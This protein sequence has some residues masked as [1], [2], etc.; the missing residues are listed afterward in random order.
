MKVNHKQMYLMLKTQAKALK[1]QL[2]PEAVG[3][4]VNEIPENFNQVG[5][6]LTIEKVETL[7][8]KMKA[9]REVRGKRLTPQFYRSIYNRAL[10]ANGEI[11][12]LYETLTA[13]AETGVD[14]EAE[15]VKLNAEIFALNNQLAEKLA[16]EEAE[17]TAAEAEQAKA[18]EAAQT[19]GDSADKGKGNKTA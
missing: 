17:R 9:L 5:W 2:N 11:D 1:A 6:D 3:E 7:L 13:E 4:Q 16:K 19:N 12:K 10:I 8:N 18:A 14:Y 15:C